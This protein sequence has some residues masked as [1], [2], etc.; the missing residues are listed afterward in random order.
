[1]PDQRG[2]GAAGVAGF[3]PGPVECDLDLVKL[4]QAGEGTQFGA[5]G[6]GYQPQLPA[7]VLF[8]LQFLE[9]FCVH[10]VHSPSDNSIIE[11]FLPGGF[12]NI[13]RWDNCKS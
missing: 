13:V 4:L 11:M 6:R 5:P 2:G 10:S 3:F 8:D 9:R 1:M 7:L 12:K